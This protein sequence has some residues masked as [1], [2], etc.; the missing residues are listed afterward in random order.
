MCEIHLRQLT[1]NLWLS[2]GKRVNTHVILAALNH[3]N[4][5]ECVWGPDNKVK[6]TAVPCQEAANNCLVIVSGT[7][8]A[9][10][11]IHPFSDKMLLEGCVFSTGLTHGGR[12]ESSTMA[13]SLPR[14]QPYK[15]AP[16]IHW[17][18]A[19]KKWWRYLHS[20]KKKPSILK[21]QKFVRE[22]LILEETQGQIVW[23]EARASPQMTRFRRG[24][25]YFSVCSVLCD[26]TLSLLFHC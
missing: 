22:R 26:Y 10:L 20:E 11:S 2:T 8:T 1:R 7:I 19:I 14:W 15:A 21:S 6:F 18:N 12:A 3:S 24:N 16:I 17:L 5:Q 9:A 4:D 13:S 25:C 23:W